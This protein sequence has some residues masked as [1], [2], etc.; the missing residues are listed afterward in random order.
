VDHRNGDTTNNGDGN[1]RVHS[2]RSSSQ[3]GGRKRAK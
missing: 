2:D 1:L 3:Q